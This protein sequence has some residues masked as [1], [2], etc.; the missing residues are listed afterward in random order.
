MTI[1][2]EMSYNE[3]LLLKNHFFKK[4]GYKPHKFQKLFHMSPCRFKALVAGSRG[5]KSMAAAAEAAPLLLIPGVIIWCVSTCYKLAEKEY[6]WIMT[7]VG[8]YEVQDGTRLIDHAHIYS[9]TKGSKS[10][11]FPWGSQVITCSTQ[12]MSN[13]LGEEIDVCILGETSQIPR[14]VWNN[15][16]RARLGSRNGYAIAPSTGNDDDGL[17]KDFADRGYSKE[18]VW[19]DWGVWQFR[20]CDN[21]TF[22]KDEYEI[23]RAELDEKVFAEQYEGKFV[24]KRGRVFPSFDQ[25][26]I[27]SEL[28]ENFDSFPVMV[29]VH[30]QN[31]A[32]NNPFTVSF[33]ARNTDKE[34]YIVYDEIHETQAS[35]EILLQKV[36]EKL[37]GKRLIFAITDY[38]N[39]ALQDVLKEVFPNVMV[40]DEKKYTQAHCIVRRIQALQTELKIREDG[41]PR[42]KVLASCENHIEEFTKCKWHFPK[43]EQSEMA[44]TALP[45]TKYIS[46]PMAVSYVIAFAW[47]G[48]GREIYEAQRIVLPKKN[49]SI[50]SEISRRY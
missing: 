38:F 3:I 35:P 48:S 15:V 27:I 49:S 24:S 40:N 47:I 30:H 26:R 20:T 23:A 6:N 50:I 39:P 17:L 33:I 31:N 41:E 18:K 29:G 43:S 21:P 32:F 2:S 22:S 42:L 14:A 12:K 19:E 1:L 4:V 8:K 34:E 5:G 36:A 25:K 46:T 45:T 10:M 9:P 44:E 37:R 7:F 11:V 28:P 16:L 13:L